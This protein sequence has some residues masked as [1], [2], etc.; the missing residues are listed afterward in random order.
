MNCRI[1]KTNH[2]PKWLTNPEIFELQCISIKTGKI[3]YTVYGKE[4]RMK[5]PRMSVEEQ[6][7]IGNNNKISQLIPDLVSNIN[8]LLDNFTEKVG[9]KEFCY[10]I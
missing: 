4:I 1:I 6:N 7:K 10:E 2:R 8:K 3:I 5:Y 9:Q